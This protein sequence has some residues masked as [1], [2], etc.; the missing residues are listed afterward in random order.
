MQTTAP[1]FSN[2]PAGFDFTAA[3]LTNTANGSDADQNQRKNS[4][5]NPKCR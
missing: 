1:A 4:Q 5:C 2:L 3:S